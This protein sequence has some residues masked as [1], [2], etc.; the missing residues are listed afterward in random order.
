V[1]VLERQFKL[2]PAIGRYADNTDA[3]D[4]SEEEVR[5]AVEA[6]VLVLGASGQEVPDFLDRIQVSYAVR[7]PVRDALPR[8]ERQ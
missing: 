5:R 8:A 7:P 4:L 6:N 2:M 1:Q 3:V